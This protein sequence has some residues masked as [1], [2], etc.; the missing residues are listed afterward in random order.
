MPTRW[1]WNSPI[2]MSASSITTPVTSSIASCRDHLRRSGS[3]RGAPQ[4]R[5][6]AELCSD[7]MAITDAKL[8]WKPGLIMASGQTSS[9]SIAPTAIIRMLNCS[10]LSTNASITSTAAMQERMVG[11]F[12]PVKRV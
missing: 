3:S 11:T 10:R 12:A 7:T 2:G 4:A 8:I 1:E 5:I 9:T 6:G